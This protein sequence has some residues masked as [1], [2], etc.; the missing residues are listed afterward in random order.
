MRDTNR[1]S[2]NE[3][4]SIEP[5]TRWLI[6][7]IAELSAILL[8]V[9][10]EGIDRQWPGFA[11]Q[12]LRLLLY[13]LAIA[14]PLMLAL[15][16]E[17]LAER[18]SYLSI[19]LL[20]LLL[21]GIAVHTGNDCLP[22]RW[23]C[24]AVSMPYWTS[25]T[26]ALFVLLPFLQ[27]WR[28]AA[29]RL[30]TGLPYTRLYHHAWDNALA[31]AAT[32]AFVAA[33]WAVLWLWGALF[34]LI[35]IPEFRELFEKPRFVY[36]VTGLVTGFGV[37]MSRA[38]GGALRAVLR[39]C[40]SLAR[41]LLPLVML[42]ALLFLA[43]VALKGP[44]ALWQ[45]RR[46][47]SLLLWLVLFGV[48]LANGV[49]QDGGA[50]ARY[51]R[52]LRRFVSA[53]LLSLPAHAG[54]AIW[55]IAL[56][57]DQHGW[58]PDRLSAALVAVILGLHALLLAFAALPARDGR[59]LG[60]LSAS[61][62][63]LAAAVV[64]LLLASQSPLLDFRAIT[65]ASQ[66]ARLERG[67]VSLAQTKSC[68]HHA[69]DA[70]IEGDQTLVDSRN[71]PCKQVGPDGRS[72]ERFDIRLFAR[73]LGIKGRQALEA[74][75]ADARYSGDTRLVAEIDDALLD[76]TN[77]L[78]KPRS[79]A[80]ADVH[81]LP[82]GTALPAGLFE[83]IVDDLKADRSERHL[84]TLPDCHPELRI[85]VL[86]AIDLGGP[87]GAEWLFVPSNESY[88]LPPLVY[89]Q[90][91]D[92]GWQLMAWVP[93]RY[94]DIARLE[95]AKLLDQPPTAAASH[96]WPLRLDGKQFPIVD[97]RPRLLDRTAR[98]LPATVGP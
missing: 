31:L 62:P 7:A 36:P 68:G 65:V 1:D 10:H 18:F 17:R 67:D 86:M 89:G 21:A 51:P 96:W 71:R 94:D 57:V 34:A 41:A 53:G 79:L 30:P 13:T 80:A 58:T 98:P 14:P 83:A 37:V 73:E 11:D 43:V 29:T 66:L 44:E 54:L 19:G 91:A 69:T 12:G 46:A 56:R 4:T 78:P 95:A 97:G 15:T 77:F 87:D 5:A 16:I 64:V 84:G 90:R 45:T 6:V 24:N 88:Q 72:V 40:L 47:A 50:D 61:N 82:A 28:D 3:A 81:L 35:G 60:R 59:W 26:I 55:A 27:T 33:A 76:P 39:L 48:V 93:S 2:T 8:L 74:L 42:L 75:K 49:Y 70:F 38:Q 52:G 23:G 85:C 22:G 25:L 92:G 32:A 20:A 63:L 9:L